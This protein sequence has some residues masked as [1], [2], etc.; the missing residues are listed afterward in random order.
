MAGESSEKGAGSPGAHHSRELFWHTLGRLVLLYFLP[1]L[2]LAVFFQLQYRSVRRDSIRVHLQGLAEHQAHTFDLYLRER[3]ANL[4]NTLRDPRFDADTTWAGLAG[5]LEE[6]RH[7]SDAFVDLGVVRSDG[8]LVA[9]TGPVRYTAPVSYAGD[10]WFQSLCGSGTTS[11]ITD[12]YLGVRGKPHFTIAVRK[13]DGGTSYVL[14]AALSPERLTEYLTTL[15][16]ATEVQAAVANRAGVLQLSTSRVGE[17]LEMSAFV[18]PTTAPRGFVSR[19]RGVD[20]PDYAYAW[21]NEVPWALVVIDARTQSGAAVPGMLSKPLL[22]TLGAFLFMGVV[23]LVRARQVVG[24]QLATEQHE[25]ELS[26]QLVHAAKLASVGELAA[27]IA[28]EINNPLAIIAEEVGVLKDSMDPELS[29]EDDEPVDMAEHLGAIHDAV[30]RCRDITR[31]LLTFVRAAEVKV[32]LHDVHDI[33][34][35]VLDVLLGNE[36][37]ISNV[38]V[39]RSYDRSIG[40]ILT[41]RN[42]LCQ[43][44]VNL[45]KNALDAMPGGGHLT[46]TTQ[47]KNGQAAISIRDTGCG[48]S[49]EQLEKIFMPFYTTKDPGKGTGLGLSVSYT[50]IRGFGG[51]FYVV[52]APGKGST[53]TVKLPVQSV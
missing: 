47:R 25:A 26:G 33:L 16:G 40:L 5:F 45:V 20:R 27:G 4:D 14:R 2:L 1:L 29:S 49:P 12:I 30:F 52:S 34:D 18:P 8:A 21:L 10:A 9:Y 6:L 43:V 42:Q 31:K 39:E 37:A 17:P 48:M 23:I 50:I 35:E 11:V 38:I 22:V 36:L 53:F 13:D 46:V 28:H 32:E 7:I 51:A 15:E 19:R 24:V 44:F 41:D 3:L